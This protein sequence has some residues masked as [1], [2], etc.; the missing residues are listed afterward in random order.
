VDFWLF[1]MRVD[2]AD[3]TVYRVNGSTGTMSVSLANPG[4]HIVGAC[5]SKRAPVNLQ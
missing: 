4:R 1:L 5:L 3:T 2:D